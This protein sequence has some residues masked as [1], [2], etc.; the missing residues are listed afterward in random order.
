MNKKSLKAVV[1]QETYE[2]WTKM[3]HSLVPDGRTHRL[4]TMI[5]GMLQYAADVAYKRYG[6]GPEEG[7]I[8]SVLLMASEAGDS[9]DI[10]NLFGIV[11]Q[12]FKDAGVGHQRVNHRGHGYSIAE[13]AIHEFISWYNMP[14][15]S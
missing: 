6:D 12:L 9:D 1:G 14:W 7:S 5:A 11:E 4:A 8:A 3:L 2:V 13:S 15:E 10:P